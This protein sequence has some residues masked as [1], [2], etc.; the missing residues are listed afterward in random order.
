MTVGAIR[1]VFRRCVLCGVTV[2]TRIDTKRPRCADEEACHARRVERA[3][4]L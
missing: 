4:G 3:P 1:C 2:L